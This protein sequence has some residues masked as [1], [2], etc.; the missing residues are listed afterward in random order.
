MHKLNFQLFQF[1]EIF[2]KHK[3]ISLMSISNAPVTLLSYII[4]YQYFLCIHIIR[5]NHKLLVDMILVIFVYHT[6][7]N[8]QSSTRIKCVVCRT[9]I[10]V[11]KMW[12]NYTEL[13]HEIF[14]SRNCLDKKIEINKTSFFFF[15]KIL[16]YTHNLLLYT[17]MTKNTHTY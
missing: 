13:D 17:L 12:F 16:V 3:V 15:I 14:K 10:L 5:K 8:K 11:N 9:I 4:M 6:H 2:T 7:T 1:R